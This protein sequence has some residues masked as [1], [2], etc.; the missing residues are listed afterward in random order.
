MGTQAGKGIVIAGGTGLVGTHLTQA[1]V[2]QGWNVHILSRSPQPSGDS[3]IQIHGWDDL[4]D[5]LEGASALINLAGEGI[6]DHRW[7]QARKAALLESRINPTQRLVE[8]L[9]IAKNPPPVFVNASAIGIYGTHATT[10]V[11]EHHLPGTGFLAELCQRWEAAADGALGLRVIKLRLGVVLARE[12]GALEKI[13]LPIR[14]FAGTALGTGR[15]GFSW[16]HIEDVVSL[17][18]EAIENPAYTGVMNAT[19]PHPCSNAELTRHI[20]KRLH[21]PVWPI[22]GFIT[23]TALKLLVGEM[24]EPMLLGGAYVLPAKAQALGFQFRFPTIEESLEDLL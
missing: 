23:A 8:A 20:A 5:L 1:L 17:I 16:I 22:P 10:P 11:D 6:A 19:S 18:L 15:Q 12:G 14:Y 2:R 13:V 3:S 7:S 9:A 24:A 21:R 4:P